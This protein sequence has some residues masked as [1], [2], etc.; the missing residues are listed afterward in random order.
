MTSMH[1]LTIPGNSPIEITRDQLRSLLSEIETELH[2]SKVYRRALRMLEKLLGASAEQGQ[3]LFK[4]VTREAI[5]LAFHKFAQQQH[6]VEDEHQL[7]DNESETPIIEEA[8]YTELSQCLTSVKAHAN[9]TIVTTSPVNSDPPKEI[10]SPKKKVL[11]TWFKSK[12]KPSK[13]ELAKQKAAE[14]RVESLRQIGQQ[15]RQARESQNLSLSQLNVYTHVPIHYMEAVENGN[16]ESLPEDVF[17]RGFVRVMGNALALNGTNLAGSLPAPELAKFIIPPKYQSKRSSVAFELP[18]IRPVHLYLGYTALVAGSIGG[19]SV[20]SQQANANKLI[21]SQAV[22]PSSSFTQ[23]QHGKKQ[24][25][26][27]PGLQSSTAGVTV[28]SDISPPEAL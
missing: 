24:S 14:Q 23:S 15:L 4:A 1:L 10:D 5:G 8:D 28:G 25:I 13:A 6:K 18:A 20:I 11:T 2:Q 9:A 26:T 16:W 12:K 21:D 7:S 17:V 19:L 3:A 22:T 27:K